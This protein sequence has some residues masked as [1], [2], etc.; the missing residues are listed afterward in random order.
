M[1]QPAMYYLSRTTYCLDLGS[2]AV[3][4]DLPHDSYL[5]IDAPL[6][7]ALRVAIH[8]WPPCKSVIANIA[9]VNQAAAQQVMENLLRRG[10]LTRSPTWKPITPVQDVSAAVYLG[11]HIAGTRHMTLTDVINFIG[12]LLTV[13]I[14]ARRGPLPLVAWLQ[15]HRLKCGHAPSADLESIKPI[16]ATFFRLRVLFYTAQR[17]CLFDSLVLSV[18]LRKRGIPCTFAIGVSLKPFAAHSWVQIGATVLNDT[19]EH[20][21]LFTPILRLE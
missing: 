4:L 9:P 7:P 17:R 11:D 16:L 8:N 21:Q 13:F 19:A 2:N 1:P 14:Q 5:G 10:V 12:S 18:F 20:A 3:M 15:T 6:L